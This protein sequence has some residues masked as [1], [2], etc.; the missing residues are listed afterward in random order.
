MPARKMRTAISLRLAAMS[1]LIGRT[2]GTVPGFKF[3]EA[4]AKSGI[5]WTPAMMDTWLKQPG[6][7]IPGNG[8]AF[9]G[10]AA[11]DDRAAVIA[12]ML[13]NTGKQ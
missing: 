2:A 11:D 9:P 12:Y 3:T 10:I 5:V 1:F 7:M 4:M 8:M 13:A 6:A